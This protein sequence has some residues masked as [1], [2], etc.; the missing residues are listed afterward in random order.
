MRDE[1]YILKI[2]DDILG[3]EAIRQH[4]FDFL[5]GDPGK[6]TIGRKLPVDGYYEKHMLVI[7]YHE[8]QHFEAVNH[9][10]KLDKIT[11]S[12]VP[13]SEQRKRYDQR[14]RDVLRDEKIYLVEL[15]CT[16]F[17]CSAN[18]RLKR[19]KENDDFVIRKKLSKFLQ[20]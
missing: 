18:K 7:E 2:C 20:N 1:E 4:S 10:D 9:F 3:C 15:R 13:R 5:R 6:R 8:R 16:E 11:V 14:R 19:N 17:D 12:G